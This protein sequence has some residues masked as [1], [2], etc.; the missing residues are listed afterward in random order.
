MFSELD[1][2]WLIVGERDDI[3][4]ELTHEIAKDHMIPV[5]FSLPALG[6]IIWFT[7]GN[8]FRPL[9]KISGQVEK[10]EYE[11]L[12]EIQ[13]GDIPLEVEE[14]VDAIN[15]LFFRLNQS[16]QREQ[17]FVSDA[18]HELRNPLAGVLVHTENILRQQ[19]Q[20]VSATELEESLSHI[21]EST[22]RLSHLVDQLLA[23]SRAD[24]E[25]FAADD[26]IVD[27]GVL[28][29]EVC[30]TLDRSSDKSI[31]HDIESEQFLTNGNAELIEALI[32]NLVD[33]AVRHTPVDAKVYVECKKT[34]LGPQLIVDD[35]GA[36]IPKREREAVLRRFYRAKETDAAGS[37]LGLAIVSQIAALHLAE[38]TFTESPHG[39]LSVVVKFKKATHKGV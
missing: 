9:K 27:L 33:N 30:Y 23:L 36:G 7:L 8:G 16:Y 32:R 26:S 3:R 6:L 4:E 14:L 19:T 37:G 12:S 22:K 15:S 18:A 21:Q 17:Q 24:S 29:E 39:G 38:M 20:N 11:K 35:S 25:Y 34:D 1:N 2:Y 5:L 13:A 28:A 10:Q 31:V